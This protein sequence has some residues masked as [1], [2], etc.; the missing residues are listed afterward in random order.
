MEQKRRKEENAETAACIKKKDAW[1]RAF[2]YRDE[3]RKLTT[4]TFSP[5]QRV[6]RV[7]QY[8]KRSFFP[9]H[10]RFTKSR[11]MIFSFLFYCFE[12]NKIYRNVSADNTEERLARINP[13]LIA[14][15]GLFCINTRSRWTRQKKRRR[16][17]I[18]LRSENLESNSTG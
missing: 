16:C 1:R 3:R 8:A 4:Y 5:R 13:P 15:F 17:L 12:R 6:I 9:K 7:K 2:C 18:K 10:D 14:N 11:K